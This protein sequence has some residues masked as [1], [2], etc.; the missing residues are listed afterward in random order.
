[1]ADQ[2]HGMSGRTILLLGSINVALLGLRDW[3]AGHRLYHAAAI[4]ILL[5]TF[6]FMRSLAVR[7]LQA[8]VLGASLAEILM[9]SIV[10][11]HARHP[12]TSAWIGLAALY[13]L[14]FAFIYW[15]DRRLGRA[16]RGLYSGG[17]RASGSAS[18][19][20]RRGSRL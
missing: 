9:R 12:L 17:P 10:M 2:G 20:P 5:V 7:A 8:I 3:D 4:S 13:A 16:S 15:Y 14:G 6:P 19:F 11:P 1:M 18:P